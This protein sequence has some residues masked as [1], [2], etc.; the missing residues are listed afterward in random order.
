MY[1]K[2][3][4]DEKKWEILLSKTSLN[5]DSMMEKQNI[6]KHIDYYMREFRQAVYHPILNRDIER[7]QLD[8]EIVF[9]LLL[10]K[11]NGEVWTKD[12]TKAAIAVGA[13]YAAF[14]A[15]DRI[16]TENATTTE[17]Q[18]TVL[19][20]DYWS[21]IYYKL[22]AEIPNFD[23]IQT[24][25]ATIGQINEL[26]TDY[27]FQSSSE[28]TKNLEAIKSI[29]ANCV[30]QFL[31]TFGFSKYASLTAAALPLIALDSKCEEVSKTGVEN[32]SLSEQEK[33]EAVN[34]LK[35]ELDRALMEADFIK[36]SLKEE[37]SSMT[38][39]LLRKMI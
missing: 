17:Q 27:Y 30:I 31:Y 37:V 19:A 11:L 29:K 26:K 28:F 35:V 3:K 1:W 23:F 25:S 36:T 20:G 12:M 7:P 32:W 14:E 21:G 10:P 38:R 9:F 6:K 39:S 22:L 18:L 16:D 13:V 5:G 33:T 34:L 8:E 15:H 2:R 24:L 4:L